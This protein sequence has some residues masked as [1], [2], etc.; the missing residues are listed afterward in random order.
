MTV[1]ILH[2]PY[3]D[4]AA[5]YETNLGG[6]GMVMAHEIGHAF[7]SN[8][9]L[10]DA[11]GNYDPEWISQEDREILRA[12]Q[13]EMIEYYNDFTV[14]GVYHVDGEK[15]C[16]ENY[17]DKGAMEC[18]MNGDGVACLYDGG[19]VSHSVAEQNERGAADEV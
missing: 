6:I 15:T 11:E 2:S 14:L 18:L 10:F 7:D 4:K 16:G 1:A 9:I 3:Y 19:F 17:A 12:R 5:S 13:Q 8:C